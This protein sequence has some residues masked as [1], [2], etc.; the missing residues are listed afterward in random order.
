[1][2]DRWAGGRDREARIGGHDARTGDRSSTCR[3]L[4]RLRRA[5]EG[6]SLTNSSYAPVRLVVMEGDGI[7]PEITAATLVRAA[8]RRPR[9][10]LGLRFH[11]RRHRLA[12]LRAQGTTLP[13]AAFEAAQGGRRR[14]ARAGLAQRIS[15]GREGGINPSGEL[16]K[17][18]DLYANIRPAQLARGLSAALRRR[19]SISSSCARTPKAFTPTARCSSAPASSCRRPTWRC[20]CARSRAHGSTRIARGGL[21]AGAATGAR[22]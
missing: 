3:R 2:K 19:R 1:M 21:R 5:K 6:F 15:A 8:R 10:R 17:R 12:A 9:V 18:L 4:V 13:D 22:K 14:H 7:G 20:R 16:R 11:A